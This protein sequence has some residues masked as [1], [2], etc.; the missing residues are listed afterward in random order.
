MFWLVLQIARRAPLRLLLAALAVALPVATL[1]ATLLYVDDASHAMTRV[2]LQPI[3]VEMRALATT[4]DSD[5]VRLGQQ[6]RTV[7]GV[8]QADVFASADVVVSAPGSQARVSARLFAVDPAYLAHH[9]WVH[10]YGDLRAGVLLNDAV[11][12]SPGF[13]GARRVTVDLRG[14]YKPL[15]L[16]VPVGGRADLRDATTWYAI[17]AGDVQGDIAEVPRAIVMDYATFRRTVLPA[18]R[19]A[20]GPATSITN[21]GLSEL[22]PVSLESHVAVDHGTYPADPSAAERWSGT[23]RRTLERRAPGD[24]LVADNAA[25]PLLEAGTDATNA[26]S[27]FFL[28]G[29]P[30][31]LVSAALGLAAA[32]ALAEAHRRED[33]LLRL[34]GAS[35]SHLVRLAI[36]QGTLAGSAGTVIGLVAAGAA[37]SGI[38]GHPVWRDIPAGSLTVAVVLSVLVGTSV[39]AARL[40]PLVRAGRKAALAVDRRLLPPPRPPLWR[41]AHLDAV[42]LVVGLGILVGNFASGGLKPVPVQGPALALTFYVLLAPL[43]LWLGTA[44]LAVRGLLALLARW[45]RP[46]QPRP[47]TTWPGTMLRWLGRRP[48]RTAVALTLGVLAVAFAA[49]TATFAATYRTAAHQDAQASFGA[50]LRFTPATE[51]TQP[52]PDGGPGVRA[53][54]PIRAVPARAGSDRKTI[55]AVDPASYRSAAVTAPQITRGGG[56]DTLARRANGVLVSQEIAQDFGVAPGDT[57]PVTVFPDDLDLSQKLDLHVVGVYRAFPPTDPLSEMVMSVSE[58]PAPVPPPDFYLAG[59]APGSSPG[60]VADRMR[61]EG[62]PSG[63]TV[64]TLT[65]RVRQQQRGLT[66]LNLDGL[67]RIEAVSSGAVAALGVGLLGA[68]LILERRR[69][70]AVLRTVGADTGRALTGPVVEGTVAVVGSLLIGIPLG[71]GLGVLSIRVLGLFFA[72]PPPLVTVPAGAL[73]LLAG[74]VVTLSALAL[75]LALRRIDRIEVTALLREP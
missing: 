20:L 41:R 16:S 2:A 57:I 4:L 53:M 50:D 30:G 61:Q 73:A 32:S 63:Y 25:E 74:L 69:E 39:T 3:Q 62:K 52:P 23:L 5:P 54:T 49:Q 48:S 70:F 9:P 43:L 42:A 18:V 60:A 28:L 13:S 59:V 34:R 46:D 15:G 10:A 27:L 17:P 75:G 21:P 24:V 11:A 1:A 36:E 6:L 68:F 7:P 71:L 44:L 38:V 66:A 33:A 65:E 14:D 37:V 12:A 45:S 40:I 8:K 19:H 29:I 58:V 64:S 51:V 67:S 22:P 47:L 26:R 72:L 35:D 56:L 55:M 31:V